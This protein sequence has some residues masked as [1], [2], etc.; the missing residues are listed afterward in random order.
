MKKIIIIALLV[1]CFFTSYSQQLKNKLQG[2]WVCT[3]ILDQG[4]NPTAGK[5]GESS[6]YL[7]FTFN[8]SYIS[9]TEAPFDKGMQILINY[10]EDFIDL[11]PLKKKALKYCI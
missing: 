2:S 11:F 10:G 8:K 9:I 1:T 7:E 6:E 5:F 4:G 3:K